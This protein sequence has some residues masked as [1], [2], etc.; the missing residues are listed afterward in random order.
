MPTYPLGQYEKLLEMAQ[1]Q[2]QVDDV[3]WSRIQT[4]LASAQNRSIMVFTTFT[5]IFLPLSF[6]TSVFGMNTLEWGGDGNLSLSTI[7]SISLPLSAVLI[8]GSLVAAFSFRVQSVFTRVYRYGKRAV[9]GGKGYARRL[10]PQGARDA[11][12][13]RRVD[14]ERAE[15][16]AARSKDRNYDFWA[17]VRRQRTSEYRIP[18]VNRKLETGRSTLT[19]ST[20]RFKWT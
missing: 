14:R 4:E 18:D 8:V 11:K 5:I 12:A 7:G 10:E 19:P 20:W 6:F 13:R 16:L 3:R 1:R 15:Y 9:E 2:A 17:T